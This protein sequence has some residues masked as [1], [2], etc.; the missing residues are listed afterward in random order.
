MTSVSTLARSCPL[1]GWFFQR[2]REPLSFA[3]RHRLIP[4]PSCQR[5]G[6]QPARFP[7]STTTNCNTAT[8]YEIVPLPS[9]TRQPFNAHRSSI[10]GRFS[11]IRF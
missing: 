3:S 6:F 7:G 5:A 10:R 8:L 2:Y 9:G 1:R 11:P 4:H